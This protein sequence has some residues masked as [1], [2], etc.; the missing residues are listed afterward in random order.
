MRTLPEAARSIFQPIETPPLR[1][2]SPSLSRMVEEPL[3]GRDKVFHLDGL[4]LVRVETRV[5]YPLP[6]R[7]HHRRRHGHDGNPLCAR[8]GSEPLERLDPVDP[9]EPNVHKDQ[10]R[11]S[12][13]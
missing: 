9:G 8:L 6:V 4:A 12:L 5:R 10:A 13:L 11:V 1:R 2:L 3:D 7:G